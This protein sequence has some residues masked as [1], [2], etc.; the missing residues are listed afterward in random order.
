LTGPPWCQEPRHAWKP[1]EIS[2]IS[3]VHDIVEKDFIKKVISMNDQAR[4][5][6]C[7]MISNYGPT[8][9]S[10]PR[11]C[12]MVLGQQC[13][14]FP[15]EK[16]LLLRALDRG[17]VADV[18]KGPVGGPWD[19]QVTRVAGSSVKPDDARWAV[20]SWAIA[21]GK[22]PD[23]APPP[24]KPIVSL[25]AQEGG[26]KSGGAVRA[27]GSTMAV[28]I[29]GAIGGGITGMTLF[30][31]MVMTLGTVPPYNE[32]PSAFVIVL[33]ALGALIGG[34][35]SGL[36]AALGWVVIQTQSSALSLTTEQLNRRLRKGFLGALTGAM[37]GSVVPGY[38]FGIFGLFFG[39]FLGGLGG[40][41]S[42]GM[43][44]AAGGTSRTY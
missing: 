30:L 31:V 26:T 28:A 35:G 29:G 15:T 43:A 37:I 44:G 22:H 25:N 32:I 12:V 21:L 16:N 40:A 9:C 39:A 1:S 4:Q 20:E 10:T 6:L 34:V 8:I 5:K 3:E 13:A 42:G 2:S 24:P 11:T 41:V 17:A 19:E 33:V 14:E 38:C 36:G 27:A 7:E 18:I 23:A